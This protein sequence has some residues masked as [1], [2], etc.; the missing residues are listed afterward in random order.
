MD[1]NRWQ[2]L[3]SSNCK[4]PKLWRKKRMVR[5]NLKEKSQAM[6]HILSQ[7]NMMMNR[8]ARN[9]NPKNFLSFWISMDKKTKMANTDWIV[10][11]FKRSKLHRQR[12]KSNKNL[13]RNRKTFNSFTRR[14]N[15]TKKRPKKERIR[16]KENHKRQIQIW[17]R[18]SWRVPGRLSKRRKRN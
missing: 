12:K 11:P 8:R 1:S 9:K 6:I 7:C 2:F 5:A 15:R 17:W 16:S 13:P 4:C 10:K 14:K 18:R 3:V